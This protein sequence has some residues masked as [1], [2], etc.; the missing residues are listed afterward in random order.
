MGGGFGFFSA[1]IPWSHVP[2]PKLLNNIEHFVKSNNNECINVSVVWVVFKSN[3]M[4]LDL[5]TIAIFH[6]IDIDFV[7]GSLFTVLFPLGRMGFRWWQS[8]YFKNYT[9][10]RSSFYDPIRSVC[11]SW[12]D[13]WRIAIIIMSNLF[14]WLTEL[15]IGSVCIFWEKHS[16]WI[17]WHFHQSNMPCGRVA[18]TI[19]ITIIRIR[20]GIRVVD[21]ECWSK[22]WTLFAVWLLQNVNRQITLVWQKSKVAQA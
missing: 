9:T 21:V 7:L 8:P 18:A 6:F 17:R 20:I 11:R 15:L 2:K 13:C 4:P 3:D 1:F 16:K 12:K 22:S 14:K 19:M 5:Q 10:V